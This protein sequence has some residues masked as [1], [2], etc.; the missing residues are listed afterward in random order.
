MLNIYPN[1]LIHGRHA[2]ATFLCLLGVSYLPVQAQTNSPTS[3]PTLATALASARPADNETYITLDPDKVNVPAGAYP[4]RPS[5]EITDVATTYGLSTEAFG[6]IVAIAPTSITVV[7][8]PPD[9]PNP[10][11]GMSPAQAIKLLAKTFTPNEWTAFF[12]DAGIGYTDLTDNSQQLLFQA[13]FPDGKMS[14]VKLSGNDDTKRDISGA[15]LQE[16]HLRLRFSMSIALPVAGKP[17]EYLFDSY[18][19]P[20][21]SHPHY[22]MANASFENNADREFGGIVRQTEPNSLKPGHLDFDAPVLKTTVPVDHVK[23]LDDLMGRIAAATNL[24]LYVDARYGARKVTLIGSPGPINASNLL[25]AIAVCVG[26]TYRQVGP[27]FL[28]TNDI[29][30]L[31]VKH[32]LWKRFEQRASALLTSGDNFASPSAPYPNFPYTVMDIPWGNDPLAFT[33]DQRNQ[34]WN[35]WRKQGGQST[36]LV[37]DLTL[38]VDQLSPAQRDA[39]K[40]IQQAELDGHVNTTLSGKVMIQAEAT[41]EVTIPDIDGPVIIPSS[42]DGLLPYPKLT[43]TEQNS[44]QAHFDIL[45]PA[46]IG[47]GTGVNTITVRQALQNFSHRA[48]RII[49]KTDKDMTESIEAARDLGFNEIWLKITPVKASTDSQLAILSKLASQA[50]NG[51]AVY[52]DIPILEANGD[53]P[54]GW[55]DRNLEGDT[56]TA[57]AAK[58]TLHQSHVNDTISPFEPDAVSSI[59][60]LVDH[61]AA[62]TGLA[63][64]VWETIVSSGYQRHGDH[65]AGSAWEEEQGYTPA[66]R[67]A[68]LRKEHSDP[69][70]LYTNEY[71]DER[72]HVSIP[73]YDDNHELT[74]E[75]CKHWS[76]FRQDTCE[77]LR[78]TLVSRLPVRYPAGAAHII[79]SPSNS[80][81]STHYGRWDD[82]TLPSP[83]VDYIFPHSP[84]GAPI[85]GSIGTERMPSSVDYRQVMS[86]AQ[87][88][89]SDQW[90][91]A[92]ANGIISAAV[93]NNQ[94]LNIVLDAAGQPGLLM[95]L[96]KRDK[97]APQQQ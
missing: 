82:L 20:A 36:R 39:A 27:A 47:G 51:I 30:G 13:L 61:T 23:T 69:I 11:D 77:R 25:Q 70:D 3:P 93:D 87:G 28:L 26:G 54:D 16:A 59:E 29:E 68:F 40:H 41:V 75:L 19:E 45:P 22:M 88:S 73:G 64:E 55:R 57:A 80:T 67:L 5:D 52:A 72:A 95:A 38:P 85:I 76:R 65:E 56:L 9:E 44:I 84:D 94:T 15:T 74:Q 60:Q 8:V 10:Y 92:A 35:E 63:G 50:G 78:A 46:R 18:Y 37:M 17:G 21:T 12:S 7:N 71:V 96:S 31:G 53:T 83:T 49:A 81:F 62:I 43:P 48:V 66:G 34:Y 33:P 86:Y 1:R 32:A 89:N 4:A 14:V 24:E 91:A 79:V 58:S 2:T 6:R 42:Y 90:A 97:P